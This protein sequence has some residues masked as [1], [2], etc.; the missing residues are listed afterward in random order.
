ML[1]RWCLLSYLNSDNSKRDIR[2]RIPHI[3]CGVSN[4]EPLPRAPLPRHHRPAPLAARQP[5]E[6]QLE[7]SADAIF[8]LY[9]ACEAV[10]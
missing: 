2:R 1:K 9:G 8:E 6:L 7:A 3:G 10:S 5:H 4:H